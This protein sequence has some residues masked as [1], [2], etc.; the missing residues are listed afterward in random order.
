[1]KKIENGLFKAKKL[2]VQEDVQD[3]FISDFLKNRRSAYEWASSL[4]PNEISD[5]QLYFPDHYY[6][7]GRASILDLLQ[8]NQLTR[9]PPWIILSGVMQILQIWKPSFYIHDRS[10]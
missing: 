5:E 2:V 3:Y 10:N 4:F 6:T 9:T 7:N 1:M 8:V